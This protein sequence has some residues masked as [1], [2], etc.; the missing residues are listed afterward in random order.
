[1]RLMR[2]LVD[3]IDACGAS[4]VA[5]PE[6]VLSWPEE[7]L[8]MRLVGKVIDEKPDGRKTAPI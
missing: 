2:R 3:M 8:R 5:S 1:M 6:L 7:D 4:S